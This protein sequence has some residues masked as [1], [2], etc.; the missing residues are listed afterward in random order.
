MNILMI[1]LG[2]NRWPNLNKEILTRKIDDF[3][4]LLNIIKNFVF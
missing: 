3:F 1:S 4:S 2:L